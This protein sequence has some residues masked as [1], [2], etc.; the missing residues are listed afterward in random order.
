MVFLHATAAEYPFQS[1]PAERS[2]TTA[3]HIV[4]DAREPCTQMILLTAREIL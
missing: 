4:F 1:S 3:I 2:D